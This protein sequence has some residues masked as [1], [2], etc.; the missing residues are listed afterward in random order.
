[1]HT[2]SMNFLLIEMLN[3][4]FSQSPTSKHSKLGPS[5][6]SNAVE[7]CIQFKNMLNGFD[8]HYYLY[9]DLLLVNL[10]LILG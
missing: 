5:V 7:I 9:Q 1:M 2:E 8:C 4:I 3:L 6:Y 10:A